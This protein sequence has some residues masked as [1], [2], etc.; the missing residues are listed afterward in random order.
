MASVRK[1]F[2]SVKAIRDKGD[3]NAYES[4]RLAAEREH[5]YNKIIT[6]EE[7]SVLRAKSKA[8]NVSREEPDAKFPDV[9]FQSGRKVKITGANGMWSKPASTDFI[10]H[11]LRVAGSPA[12]VL[13]FIDI[14]IK[15]GYPNVGEGDKDFNNVR[16]AWTRTNYEKDMQRLE[17]EIDATRNYTKA[18]NDQ[19]KMKAK[20]PS[21]VSAEQVVDDKENGFN[22]LARLY[23]AVDAQTKTSRGPRGGPT[24]PRTAESN[25]KRNRAQILRKYNDALRSDDYYY[26][27][28]KVTDEYKGNKRVDMQAKGV[29]SE[30]YIMQGKLAVPAGSDIE[31]FKHVRTAIDEI[32]TSDEF[33]QTEKNQAERLRRDLDQL[34]LKVMRNRSPS[35]TR[36]ISQS[37]LEE[38][39]ESGNITSQFTS[40]SPSKT[41]SSRS[42]RFPRSS[43]SPFAKRP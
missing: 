34:E 4:R 2:A 7:Q 1:N 23:A 3:P 22:F 41:P 38:M 35:I 9:F 27:P 25:K 21:R 14:L 13:G 24:G 28:S 11:R 29:R 30:D 40:R 33:D 16:V 12:A 26:D 10:Y 8:R 42:P 6:R 39:K 15:A 20:D 36:G 37:R 19:K 32:L 18:I 31:G 5:A 17:N 43:K